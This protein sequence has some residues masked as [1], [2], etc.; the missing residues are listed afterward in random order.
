MLLAER[1]AQFPEL[2]GEVFNLS[3][4]QPLTVLELVAHILRTM[5]AVVEPVVRNEVHH[6]I[7][8]QYLSARKARE[9]LGWRPLFTLEQGLQQT[10]EWYR[11][12]LGQSSCINLTR[13]VDLA[14]QSV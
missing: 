13:S 3:N 1:L 9:R 14:A 10:I 8:D 5:N 6:E 2:A 4:E 7:R 12:F 11:S